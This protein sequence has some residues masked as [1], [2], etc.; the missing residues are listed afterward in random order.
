VYLA[1]R[2]F[3]EQRRH[4]AIEGLR[5]ALILTGG[6]I[7]S[8]GVIMAGTLVS[9]AVGSLRTMVELG[10]ALSLGIIIDTFVVRSVVVPTF[11]ALL[12]RFTKGPAP[13]DNAAP[14][15]ADK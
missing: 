7:T 14:T 4:G 12:A 3:E 10:F 11:L 1:T 2:V 6:I 13:P 8:C 9:M 15:P 5:R